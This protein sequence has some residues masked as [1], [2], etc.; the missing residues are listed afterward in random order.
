MAL[1][2]LALGLRIA[3]PAHQG[4]T[5][6]PY[7][8]APLL[9]IA[10]SGFVIVGIVPAITAEYVLQCRRAQE[11]S[12]LFARHSRLQPRNLFGG[13][14]VTLLDMRAIRITP[15]GAAAS[16]QGKNKRAACHADTQRLD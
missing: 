15:F 14:P 16:R 1:E 2:R 11:E 7:T 13:D 3:F 5:F 8:E 6:E 10:I 4:I 12:H 9:R